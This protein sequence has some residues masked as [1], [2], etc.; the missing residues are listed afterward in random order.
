MVQLHS[1]SRVVLRAGDLSKTT[2]PLVEEKISA[3]D[4]VQLSGVMT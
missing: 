4:S 2:V 1:K 3:D